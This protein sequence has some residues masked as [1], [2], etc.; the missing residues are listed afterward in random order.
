M[1][2]SLSHATY[3]ILL[4]A[5]LPDIFFRQTPKGGVA[6]ASA[7]GVVN[8]PVGR[9]LS[10]AALRPFGRFTTPA[11]QSLGHPSFRRRGAFCCRHASSLVVQ[12]CKTRSFNSHS[13]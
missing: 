3:F 1:P 9:K 4:R 12:A 2:E 10:R 11:S 13:T 5:A 8:R 7:D 6:A